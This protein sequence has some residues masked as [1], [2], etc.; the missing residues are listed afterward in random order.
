[1]SDSINDNG[2][3]GPAP[4]KASGPANHIFRLTN[5]LEMLNIFSSSFCQVFF[6]LVIYMMRKDKTKL[7]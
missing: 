3:C 4:G 5:I 6:P 2:V 7:G 1:M